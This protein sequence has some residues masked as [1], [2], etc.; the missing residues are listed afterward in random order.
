MRWAFPW[1]NWSEITMEFEASSDFKQSVMSS[2]E[3]FDNEEKKDFLPQKYDAFLQTG[4]Q[5]FRDYTFLPLTDF[6][7]KYGVQAQDLGLEVCNIRDELGQKVSGVMFKSANEPLRIRV[8]AHHGSQLT[9]L[10]QEPKTQL[11]AKQAEDFRTKHLSEKEK[12]LP[13][14]MFKPDHPKDMINVEELAAM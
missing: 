7:T 1:K 8:V 3:C 13:K 6:T 12:V 11:R 4:Y 5:A 9:D 10:L 14:V 2:I